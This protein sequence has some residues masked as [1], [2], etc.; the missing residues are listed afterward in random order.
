MNRSSCAFRARFANSPSAKN[1]QL[2]T[3]SGLLLAIGHQP[4]IIIRLISDRQA[5][6]LNISK[7]PESTC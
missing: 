3:A 4:K 1:G 6:S 5:E 2:P 7:I